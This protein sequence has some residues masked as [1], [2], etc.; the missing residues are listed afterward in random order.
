M[1]RRKIAAQQMP[2]RVPASVAER[3]APTK[4]GNRQTARLASRPPVPKFLRAGR[5]E[6]L[7]LFV[8]QPEMN[9]QTQRHL[10]I[11]VIAAPPPSR[12]ANH[13]R[14]MIGA[15]RPAAI[16]RLI[17]ELRRRLA[18]RARVLRAAINVDVVLL[19]LLRPFRKARKMREAL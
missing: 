16:D 14:Q 2:R 19:P 11:I 4:R 1:T 5:R 13:D 6:H 9:L 15:R 10:R 17:A 3:I 7:G 12:P 18:N 8:P